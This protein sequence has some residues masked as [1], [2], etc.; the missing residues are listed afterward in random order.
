MLEQTLPVPLRVKLWDG[1]CVALSS[2]DK[3]A[4][5]ISV[6]APGVVA[7][8]LKR[9]SLENLVRHYA[10]GDIA[11]DGDLMTAG[12][13][14]RA[15][16]K[17]KDIKRLNKALLLRHL[18]PFLLT[19]SEKAVPRHEYGKGATEH[20]NSSNKE[21]IQ[22]HYDV[23]NDFY[24]L[25]LD[26][27]M[28]YSCGYFTDWSN[29]LEQAQQDKLEMICRKLRLKKGERFLDIGC[30]WGGLICHAAKQYGVTCARHHLVAG[31]ARF[32]ARKNPR[33]WVGGRR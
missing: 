33:A 23:G 19:R 17:K 2:E 24:K 25:F 11:F 20:A 26:P 9:P 5:V 30:G 3:A 8:L 18:W 16:L 28:Q 7:S 21:Y 4:P 27:E 10:T 32:H 1:S 31:A 29:S 6:R 22:F 15:R 13:A 14:V 12:E